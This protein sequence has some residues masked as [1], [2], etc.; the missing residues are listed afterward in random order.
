MIVGPSSTRP[1]GV[2]TDDGRGGRRRHCAAPA[3]P[4]ITTQI[5]RWLVQRW[6]A[7]RRTSGW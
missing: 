1:G 4:P 5:A 6:S 3:T 7:R 2:A